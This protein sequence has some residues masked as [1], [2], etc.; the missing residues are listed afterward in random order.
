[1]ECLYED[2]EGNEF[3][4]HFDYTPEEKDVYYPNDAACQGCAAEVNIWAIIAECDGSDVIDNADQMGLVC[5]EESCWTAVDDYHARREA[6][7]DDAAEARM[8]DRMLN[9]LGR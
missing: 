1:M 6:E 4:I 3:T 9:D 7:R 2:A 5:L 8:E